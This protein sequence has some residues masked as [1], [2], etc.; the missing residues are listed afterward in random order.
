M[1]MHDNTTG[2][3]DRVMKLKY[4]NVSYH[5]PTTMYHTVT[6]HY[7]GLDINTL[8]YDDREHIKLP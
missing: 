2:Y 7:C 8:R 5:L 6:L 3:D 1:H 4:H